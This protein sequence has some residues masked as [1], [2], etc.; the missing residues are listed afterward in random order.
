MAARDEGSFDVVHEHVYDM[1]WESLSSLDERSLADNV[2]CA[3]FLAKII[4]SVAESLLAPHFG[5]AIIDELFSRFTAIIA[6][7]IKK[8]KGKFV[9]LIVTVRRRG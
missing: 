4:R 5:R 9:I 8:E 7:H 3:Q 1:N 2:A 6:E